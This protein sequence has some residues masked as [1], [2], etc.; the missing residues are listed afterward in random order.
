MNTGF[1]LISKASTANVF[2]INTSSLMM[3]LL[4]T[5]PI[6]IINTGH[7]FSD[8]RLTLRL[9]LHFYFYFCGMKQMVGIQ[10]YVSGHWHA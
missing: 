4:R 8:L 10:L 9:P 6:N 2:I 1:A 3:L 7:A 5:R